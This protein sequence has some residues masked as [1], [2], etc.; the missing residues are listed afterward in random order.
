MLFTSGGNRMTVTLENMRTIFKDAEKKCI[1]ACINTVNIQAAETRKNAIQNIQGNFILRNQWTTS[2]R[3]LNYHQCPKGITDI[4]Q[5]Q[6]EIGSTLDY[7]ERQEKGG[8]RKPAKGSQLA[9]PSTMARGGSNNKKVLSRLY[10]NKIKTV[11][12]ATKA[13]TRSSQYV[14][15]A[16][17]ASKY[18]LFLS[19]N[20]TLFQVTNFKKSGDKISFTQT[21]IYNLKFKT[22]QTKA[23]PWL[24]PAADQPAKDAQN[25]YNYQLDKIFMGN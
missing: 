14:A 22:T 16:F 21:P 3:N 11:G 17:I 23:K 10:L 13:T 5:I 9:I 15:R 18:K 1:Q 2:S 24:E 7:M 6:S 25:I 19:A 20:K 4:T 12:R 8:T